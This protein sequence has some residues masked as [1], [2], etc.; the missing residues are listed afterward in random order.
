[1]TPENKASKSAEPSTMPY[2]AR[3]APMTKYTTNAVPGL[4][5]LKLN[6]DMVLL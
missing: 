6:L 3:S 4:S 1:M 5:I 2:S